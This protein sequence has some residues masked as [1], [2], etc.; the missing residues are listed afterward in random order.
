MGYVTYYSQGLSVSLHRLGLGRE[1]KPK[2]N[3]DKEK[4]MMY[5][6]RVIKCK[7]ISIYMIVI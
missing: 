3:S 5:A 4:E 2:Y 7:K 6:E 1:N